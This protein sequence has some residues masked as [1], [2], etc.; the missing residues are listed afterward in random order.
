MWREFKNN[1]SFPLFGESL[2]I[3]HLFPLFAL[4]ATER[5][6]GRKT[7]EGIITRTKEEEERQDMEEVEED[8]KGGPEDDR[9]VYS[10]AVTLLRIMLRNRAIAQAQLTNRRMFQSEHR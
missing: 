6:R 3:I 10:V 5:R 8:S 2:K 1:S 4:Q 7:E 9:A